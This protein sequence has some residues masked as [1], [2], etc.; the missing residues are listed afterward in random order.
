MRSQMDPSTNDVVSGYL[1]R[2]SKTC[3]YCGRSNPVE[4]T[5]CEECGIAAPAAQLQAKGINDPGLPKRISALSVATMALLAI[6][7]LYWLVAIANVFIARADSEEIARGNTAV[8]YW[9][10]CRNFIIAALCFGAR[11]MMLKGTPAL[12]AKAPFLLSV[13]LVMTAFTWRADRNALAWIEPLIVW[14]VL[15]FGAA[16]AYKESRHQPGS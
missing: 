4:A 7:M 14:P 15:L 9:A 6:A 16:I 11:Q 1:T 8:W 2:M 12:S 13:A 3:G 10:A 5:H